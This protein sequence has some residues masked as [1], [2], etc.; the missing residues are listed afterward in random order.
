M[1]EASLR[2]IRNARKGYEA[3]RQQDWER[4]RFEVFWNAKTQ[5][6]TIGGQDLQNLEQ[7]VVFPWEEDAQGRPPKTKRVISADYEREMLED[8]AWAEEHL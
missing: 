4:S 2:E 8:M 6:V 1:D 5:G 3:T 7:I